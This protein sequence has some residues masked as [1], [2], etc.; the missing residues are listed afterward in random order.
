MSKLLKLLEWV[1]VPQA[2]RHLSVLFGEDVTEADVLR[3][4]LDGRLRLSVYFVN[5]A[6]ARCGK[7]V[8]WEETNWQLLPYP[9]TFPKKK[10]LKKA[11]QETK[12]S[13]PFPKKLDA[14]I[15]D[16]PKAAR[17]NYFPIMDE[18]NIDGERFLALFEEVT[19][20]HGVWDLPMIGSEKLDIEHQYQV[21]TGG[22]TVTLN[23]LDG[24]FVEGRDGQICQ[25]QENYDNNEYIAGSSAALEKLKQHLTENCIKGTDA[26]LLL[27]QHKESR[28]KFLQNKNTQSEKFDYYPAGALPEDAVLVVRTTALAD[29]Q[30]RLAGEKI[31]KCSGD[32]LGTRERNT[33]LKLVIGM[34]IQGY[35]YDPRAAR[36]E[37]P[38]EIAA[39]LHK[40]AIDV[41]DDTIRKWL[42]EAAETVL[43]KQKP[44]N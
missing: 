7:V 26:E 5:H 4:A 15:N 43:P 8:P 41:T 11:E 42:R 6:E 37:A 18:L 33:L 39:D 38:A 24:A 25:L 13:R 29:F 40:L 16:I 10:V 27:S 14:L 32:P 22:P 20:L 34:A 23:C 19:T 30:A 35:C 36:N 17:G 3:L 28:K 31:D 9:D 21:L 1:T 12:E 44:K 2:A